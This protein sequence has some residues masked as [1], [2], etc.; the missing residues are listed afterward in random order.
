MGVLD[1]AGG[2]CVHTCAGM[3]SLVT[4]LFVGPRQHRLDRHG[5]FVL[6]HMGECSAK[7][8]LNSECSSGFNE[9]DQKKF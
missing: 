4:C 9:L 7:L 5:N 2:I 1:D 8:S 6:V 3:C